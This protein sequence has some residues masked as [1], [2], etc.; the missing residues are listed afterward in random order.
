MSS[1][2]L[3]WPHMTELFRVLPEGK[4]WSRS[5]LSRASEG[6]LDFLFCSVAALDY[7]YVEETYVCGSLC[8]SCMCFRYPSHSTCL[9]Q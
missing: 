8:S 1:A 5:P 3:Y 4:L 7:K 2:G 6:H 9:F